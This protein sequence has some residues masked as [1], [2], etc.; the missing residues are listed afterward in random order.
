[1][2]KGSSLGYGLKDGELIGR[3]WGFDIIKRLNSDRQVNYFDVYERNK[4]KRVRVWDSNELDTHH[5]IA[6]SLVLTKRQGAWHVDLVEV[7][8]RYKGRNLAVKLYAFL[9]K[10]LGITLMAG[11]SQSPGGRH[12]WNR[13]IKDRQLTIYA[14]KSHGSKVF[15]FPKAGKRELVSKRFDLYDSNAEIFA[16]AD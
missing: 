12:I 11:G 3:R 14:K 16:I 5:R 8:S 6:A 4:A 10:E 7:D 13:L 15:D 2:S 9:I 1:M